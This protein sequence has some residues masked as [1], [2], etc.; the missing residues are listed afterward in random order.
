[1]EEGGGRRDEGGH[2]SSAVYLASS[3]FLHWLSLLPLPFTSLSFPCFTTSHP[4]DLHSQPEVLGHV[5]CPIECYIKSV[6]LTKT[7]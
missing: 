2:P 1:M 7:V 4:L 3:L 6:Q 5:M